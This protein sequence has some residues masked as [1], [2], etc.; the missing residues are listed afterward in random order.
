[1]R[2]VLQGVFLACLYAYAY[3]ATRGKISI[4]AI[5]LLL[6]STAYLIVADDG[7]VV[8]TVCLCFG[9]AHAII[10]TWKY[11]DE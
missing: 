10:D 7:L 6:S 11:S 5:G 2:L 8:A 1:M 3:A 9:A 4:P